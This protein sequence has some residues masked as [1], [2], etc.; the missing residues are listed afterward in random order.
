MTT[1]KPTG[2]ASELS[3]P[4]TA[5]RF[6]EPASTVPIDLAAA[7]YVCEEFFVAGTASAYEAAGPL[8]H[9][10]RW[11]VAQGDSAAYRTRIVVR[12]PADP[13]RCNGTVVV[14][15]FNVSGGLEASPDWTHLGP[16]IVRDGYVYVGVSAQAF[17]VDGGQALLGV[18]GMEQGRGLVAAGP[19]RYG[20]LGHPGD[21]YA[22]DIFSQI[23]RALRAGVP[24][25]PLGPVRAE[26][27]MAMGESQSAFFLS[28]YINAVQP[29]AQAYDGFFVHSRGGSGASLTGT[30]LASPDVP[31][32]LQIRSDTSVPVL[33][34]ETETDL[35]P[36][37][38]FGPA[39]QPDVDRIRTWEVAGTAHADAYV[40][41]AFASHLGCDFLV[42]EGPQHFVAQA[43]L[44]ALERWIADDVPPPTAPPLE[45]A[46]TAPPRLARDELGNA[47]GGVR[48]PA[49]DVPVSTLS[50][51]APAGASR[52]CALFGSTVPFEDSTLLSLYGD[53][54]GY[55]AAYRRSLE[56][57]IAAGFLLESDRTELVE[58]AEAVPFP[59]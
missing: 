29:A 21:R 58:Q 48:T 26:R 2:P 3:G 1:P 33:I 39:R 22:F 30:P 35:G 37:L 4:V 7:G 51:E 12:R 41:G 11:S 16:Q 34:F 45:L 8:G 23:G 13:G 40:V 19:E 46:T 25:A 28:T 52:L 55:L 14:E 50:G 49:V 42:N 44:V 27:I 38:D 43:A 47:R 54:A 31:R 20:T 5:G 24:G 17:G 10:G 56:A 32:G 59:L 36:M 15:W 53:R 18:P 9:D 57:A 6:I